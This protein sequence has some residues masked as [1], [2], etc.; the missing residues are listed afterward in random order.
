[1]KMPIKRVNRRKGVKVI[2]PK[3]IVAY[4]QAAE[5]E[6]KARIATGSKRAI[7]AAVQTA[8]GDEVDYAMLLKKRTP[9]L[10]NK[11]PEDIWHGYVCNHL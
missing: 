6:E 9:R 10:G 2:R 3:D 1:M 5:D 7:Y 11:S 8:F 4:C